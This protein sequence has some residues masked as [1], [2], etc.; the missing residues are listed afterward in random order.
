MPLENIKN[1][2]KALILPLTSEVSM[3]MS[4]QEEIKKYPKNDLG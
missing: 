4:N 1:I 2:Q 3:M